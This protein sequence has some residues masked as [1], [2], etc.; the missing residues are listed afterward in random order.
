MDKQMPEGFPYNTILTQRGLCAVTLKYP[1]RL[2]EV[3]AA[4]FRYSFVERQAIHTSDGLLSVLVTILGQSEAEE[5]LGMCSS[6]VIKKL[7]LANTSEA[8]A[9]GSFGLP[10]YVATNS[11][12]QKEGFWGFDHLAQVADH[13]GLQ[14]PTPGMTNEGGWRALL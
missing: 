11:Q 5:I 9:E 14:R 6:D 1:E 7:L 10:W 4:L 12:G 2:E 13:L 3:I 8:L